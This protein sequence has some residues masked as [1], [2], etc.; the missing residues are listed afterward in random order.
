MLARLA[1]KRKGP[2]HIL[3]WLDLRDGAADE[4]ASVHDRIWDFGIDIYA[5]LVLSRYG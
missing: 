5:M 3:D 2:E 1:E 4:D